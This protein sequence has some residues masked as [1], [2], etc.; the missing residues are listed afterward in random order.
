MAEEGATFYYGS[1]QNL[2]FEDNCNFLEKA[3]LH[4]RHPETQLIYGLGTNGEFTEQEFKKVQTII[5]RD[6]DSGVFLHLDS[7]HRILWS[8]F[9]YDNIVHEN[10]TFKYLECFQIDEMMSKTF[11]DLVIKKVIKTD[12]QF[13]GFTLDL[14]GETEAYDFWEFFDDTNKDTLNSRYISDLTFL[15]KEKINRFHLD[16]KVEIITVNQNFICIAKN[17]DLANYL[18]SLLPIY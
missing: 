4:L 11:T 2:N 13:L 5:Y 10:F 14:Y 16:E 1:K 15:P 8:F 17:K 12:T 3:G 9:E 18:K 7:G 6:K